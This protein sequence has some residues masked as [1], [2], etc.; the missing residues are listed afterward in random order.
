MKRRDFMKLL[1]AAV[2]TPVA[3]LRAKPK[4]HPID[5]L[6]D[7][8]L[9][10]GKLAAEMREYCDEPIYKKV[11]PVVWKITAQKY[12]P[13][14]YGFYFNAGSTFQDCK[15]RFDRAREYLSRTSS[16]AVVFNINPMACLEIGDRIEM[17]VS[18]PG[19]S[20]EYKIVKIEERPKNETKA[21][22]KKSN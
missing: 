9:P 8:G 17:E 19:M 3:L 2:I 4:T 16:P 18:Q 1:G 7:L 6:I 21:I 20:G 14:I 13:A 12:N 22:H 15:E 10:N 11:K 5:V